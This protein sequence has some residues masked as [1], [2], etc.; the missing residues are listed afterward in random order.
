MIK[1]QIA[2]SMDR[3]YILELA[4]SKGWLEQPP[5]VQVKRIRM[6]EVWWVIEPYEDDCNC[7]DLVYPGS[8]A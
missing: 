2:S 6:D 3:D 8:Y 5:R 4:K 1:W 7:P